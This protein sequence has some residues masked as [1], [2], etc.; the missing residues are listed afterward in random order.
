LSLKHFITIDP[1]YSVTEYSE[2][3]EALKNNDIEYYEYINVKPPYNWYINTDSLPVF[4]NYDIITQ[5]QERFLVQK[6][7]PLFANEEYLLK[8]RE[9]DGS[10][11]AAVKKFILNDVFTE[12]IGYALCFR[13]KSRVELQ[14]ITRKLKTRV[15]LLGTYKG[16]KLAITFNKY[17]KGEIPPDFIVQEKQENELNGLGEFELMINYKGLKKKDTIR[18][19]TATAY[20]DNGK[21]H[22]I[23]KNI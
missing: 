18:K 11:L 15:Y 23:R 20:I 9:T 2:A 5:N 13:Y 14:D 4:M 10:G 19:Y 17:I 12:N 1:Y 16:W 21:V 7:T 6:T 22:P 8:R 3:I